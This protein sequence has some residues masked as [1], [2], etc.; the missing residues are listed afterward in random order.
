MNPPLLDSCVSGSFAGRLTFP[1][2]LQNVKAAGGERYLSDLVL[3]ETT[4]H[5]PGSSHYR[6]AWPKDELFSPADAFDPDAIGAALRS[7]QVGEI[8]Y[9]QFLRRIAGA[10]VVAYTVHLTGRKALYLG[11]HGDV[12]V[13]PFPP[14]EGEP[15]ATRIVRD[16]YT[17][18]G[19]R[20]L[21]RIFSLFSSDIE[22]T[23]SS[24]LPWGGRYLGPR[25]HEAVFRQ[26]GIVPPIIS[27]H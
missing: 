1:Q 19:R 7:V 10:G 18:F 3:R 8:A 17:A 5:G 21:P 14:A 11:R 20:D 24:E 4:Y 6:V 26:A 13:E 15:E 12:Y 23:Q 9:P 16:V 25:R 27:R 22:I 2:V